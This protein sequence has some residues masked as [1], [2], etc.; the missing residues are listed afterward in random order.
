[1]PEQYVRPYVDSSVF[2]AWLWGEVAK[3]VDRKAV[4]THIFKQAERGLYK[5]YISAIT[6][7]EVHKKWKLPK[8]TAPQDMRLLAFFEHEYI[9]I[10]DVDREI[11]E[12]ANELC[13]EFNLNPN[14]AIHVAC[15]LRARC[16][17]LL[18]WDS[19]FMKV[20][21][22]SLRIEEPSIIGQLEI[23]FDR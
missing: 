23:D 21:L 4:G 16:E 13:R 22:P 7:A 17:V 18:A 20:K 9:E 15:A 14:D 12:R 19:D 11:G 1:V 3:D 8:L 5:I 6:L 10:V 2:I